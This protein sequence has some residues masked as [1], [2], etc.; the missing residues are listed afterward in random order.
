MR[1]AHE[2]V[3]TKSEQLVNGHKRHVLAQQARQ[4]WRALHSLG[5]SPG[6]RRKRGL[7]LATRLSRAQVVN[8]IMGSRVSACAH[9]SINLATGLIQTTPSVCNGRR[10]N[11]VNLIPAQRALI[12]NLNSCKTACEFRWRLQ[13]PSECAPRRRT[14]TRRDRWNSLAPLQCPSLRYT[15]HNQRHLPRIVAN[16]RQL[17]FARGGQIERADNSNGGADA[18]RVRD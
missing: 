1:A 18:L 17:E 5:L 15:N 8:A 7:M 2:S 13:T 12:A 6:P 14:R 10:Q 11:L 3:D 9:T 4:K 16:Q